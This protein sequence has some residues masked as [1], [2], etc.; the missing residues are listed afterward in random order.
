MAL[1]KRLLG[2]GERVVIETRT[3]WKAVLW[4]S[5]LFVV[6][7]FVLGAGLAVVVPAVPEGARLLAGLSLSGVVVVLFV[8]FVVAPYARWLSSSYT[9]TNRRLITRQGVFTTRGH[10]LPLTRINNV[11]YERSFSDKLLG[12]GSLTL[13]TAAEE[14]LTLVD[15]P[16]V[17]NVHLQMTELLF[18]ADDADPT[19]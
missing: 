12:C 15:V 5:V 8:A 11:T 9:V 19:T 18:Q 17:E 10:D 13:T 14:P 6:L 16:D 1:S 2:D 3:H 4:P 7:C